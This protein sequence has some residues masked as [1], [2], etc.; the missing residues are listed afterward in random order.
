MKLITNINTSRIG[1]E[2]NQDQNFSLVINAHLKTVS[3]IN[4]WHHRLAVDIII[5][6]V[7]RC[8]RTAT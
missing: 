2:I 8:S 5:C 6:I 4:K 7:M 1:F 3:T